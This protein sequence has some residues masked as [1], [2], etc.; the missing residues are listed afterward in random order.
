MVKSGKVLNFLILK[1]RVDALEPTIFSSISHLWLCND[2]HGDILRLGR[3]TDVYTEEW[4]VY[5][6]KIKLCGGQCTAGGRF[7]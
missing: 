6:G 5:N 7:V 3:K 4:T 2:Q 1:N